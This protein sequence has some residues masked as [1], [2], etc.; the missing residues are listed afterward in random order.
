[1]RRRYKQPGPHEDSAEQQPGVHAEEQQIVTEVAEMADTS[2]RVADRGRQIQ[3]AHV[4]LREKDTGHGFKIEP[5][6]EMRRGQDAESSDMAA[7]PGSV[8]A[9]LTTIC[10]L[11]IGVARFNRLGGLS[12]VASFKKPE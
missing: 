11:E 12:V 8:N 1:M 5:T 2:R 10:G 3:A 9:V 7:I 6:A 4:L